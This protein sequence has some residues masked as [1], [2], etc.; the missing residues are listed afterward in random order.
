MTT[1]APDPCGSGTVFVASSFSVG[2][3]VKSSLVGNDVLSMTVT[4]SES[5]FVSGFV[6]DSTTLAG[7]PCT[8]CHASSVSKPSTR[9]AV[10]TGTNGP[11]PKPELVAPFHCSSPMN[12]TL[13]NRKQSPFAASAKGLE[14]RL[15]QR[16]VGRDPLARRVAPRGGERSR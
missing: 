9:S 15:G 11:S 3:N 14:D 5:A 8:T 16:E 7:V 4:G 2:P 6:G 1:W 12:R 10:V 13:S